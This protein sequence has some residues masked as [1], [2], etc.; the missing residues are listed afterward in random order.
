MPKNSN[1]TN[2]EF[3]KYMDNPPVYDRG[4]PY[5]MQSKEVLDFYEQEFLKITE[6][7]Y[8][9]DVFIHPFL[10]WHINYFITPIPQKDGSEKLINPPLD[11]HIWYF[12]ENY[13]RCKE[14]NLGLVLFG[15]RGWSKSTCIAS[16]LC[17]LNTT[18]EN[19][20]SEVV[21]GDD[22]DLNAISRL[23]DIGFNNVH[24]AFKLPRNKSDW[25]KHIEF[26]IKTKG[27]EHVVYSDI[28]IKNANK[29][30]KGSSE[31]GAGGSPIGFIIDEIGKFNPVEIIQSALPAFRTQYGLK[32]YAIASGTGGNQTLSKGAK[33]I[34]K[35]PSN[36][37]F[38]EMDWTTLNKYVEPEYRTWNDKKKFGMFI[39]GQMSYRL[40]VPKLD[41]DL[42][43][44]L[45]LKNSYLNKLKMKVTDWKT[46]KEHIEEKRNKLKSDEDALNKF[47]MY[48]PINVDECFLE[49]S[50]NPF[51]VRAARRKL[52]E[53]EESG[54]V[55]QRVEVMRGEQWLTKEF[56]DKELAEDPHEGG[57]ADAPVVV[58]NNHEFPTSKPADYTYVGGMD[59][60][61][62]DISDTD[63]VGAFYI[64]KR[65]NLDLNEPC[66]R[67]M[68]SYAA[69]PPRMI[70]FH[71]QCEVLTEGY[72][73][74]TCMES[75]D[76]GFI[77]HLD[78]KDKAFDLLTPA[79]NFSE[80][81]QKRPNKSNSRFGVYPTKPNQTYMFNLFLDYSK[82][83][84]VI[85]IDEDGNEIYKLGV[86]FID[87][88]DLLREI[89]R[90]KP[91]GNH[92]RIIAFM[93]ALTWCRELDKKGFVPKL[94]TLSKPKKKKRSKPKLSVFGRT[95][96]NPF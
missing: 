91:G 71:K 59:G 60:Y 27:N 70:D 52:E 2:T 40:E 89:I 54:N 43:T 73:A 6:G 31:K 29:G 26:G 42:G 4:K 39:P 68:V 56:S 36:Y 47:K 80:S 82:E 23:L 84:H 86:E 30:Q 81:A 28:F 51:P 17:W 48:H 57:E 25:K 55:G 3:Y 83:Q 8:I 94:D 45:G 10:Y 88:P 79:V 44:Y 96:A 34:L 69:R 19:G 63:S 76:T 74:Q 21:G 35:N 46:C 7:F 93:H 64:L 58:Y 18:K 92:D 9:D 95:R 15:S 12:I 16:V 14:E 11:D 22:G 5:Y 13:T 50:K 77:Q 72:G 85:D 66:E 33:Q 78:T 20:T 41:S 1:I 37:G 62:T 32:C 90:Y 49:S 75:V 67:I 53:I 24:P 65:R 61:K 87:D 38:L